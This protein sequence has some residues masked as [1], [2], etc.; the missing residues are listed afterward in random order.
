[1]HTDEGPDDMPAHVKASLM[2]PSLNIPI[3][4]GRLA[5]GTW[6]V[7]H[8]GARGGGTRVA[9]LH[10]EGG[11]GGPVSNGRLALG[12]WQV[13]HVAGGGRVCEGRCVADAVRIWDI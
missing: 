3:S 5:L 8:V 6:Q 1:M 10:G 9:V 11:M 4:N 7:G 13:G 12:T 2:G